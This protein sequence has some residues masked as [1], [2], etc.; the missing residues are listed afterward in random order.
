MSNPT[1][2]AVLFVEHPSAHSA[3][4]DPSMTVHRFCGT[5]V[6]D[7]WAFSSLLGPP[8]RFCSVSSTDWA[9]RIRL[10]V[11]TA[12]GRISS[13]PPAARGIYIRGGEGGRGERR[14]PARAGSVFFWGGARCAAWPAVNESSFQKKKDVKPRARIYYIYCSRTLIALATVCGG[15]LQRSSHWRQE[16]AR[17]GR[18]LHA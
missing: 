11:G 2:V 10:Q 5:T 16:F 9:L 6:N 3:R 18:Y 14:K 8:A 12:G 7:V 4:T 13:A 17:A 15:Q 1:A